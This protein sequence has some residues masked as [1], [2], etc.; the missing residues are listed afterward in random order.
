MLSDPY[1]FL[2]S[3]V[4]LIPGAIIAIP[5]HE[6][7]HMLA[8]EAQGEHTARRRRFL[9][10]DPRLFIEPYG[11]L[12]IFLV[13]TGWTRPA[14]FEARQLRGAWGSI[15]HALAGPAANLVVAIVAG[16]PLR[17]LLAGGYAFSFDSLSQA[18][19]D[20]ALYALYAIFFLNLSMFVFNL[21]PIPGL[22]GWEVVEA[23]FRRRYPRFF[24]DASMRRR[25][26]WV[27][28]AI[29][30]F[31]VSFLGVNLLAA[32]LLPLFAPASSA[33]LGGCAPYPGLAPCPP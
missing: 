6:F 4:F 20:L 7:G 13:R 22:D 3:A 28:C 24:F 10:P 5:A 31:I 9:R 14:P 18:P 19:L 23:I 1:L 30:L 25:E 17:V 11:L 21:L 29:A 32:V 2:V 12:A 8:A 27:V 26:I 16:I 33:I 15:G